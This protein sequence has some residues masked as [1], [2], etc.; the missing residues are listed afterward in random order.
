MRLIVTLLC[1]IL[2]AGPFVA[3][4]AA[5]SPAP[6]NACALPEQHQLDFWLGEWELSWPGDQ[7]GAVDHGT[8]SIRRT[9]DGCVVE[10]N[11]SAERSGSLRGRSLS[12]FDSSAA[13]WKQTWVDNEGSYLDFNGEFKNG[14]MIFARELTRNGQR[15]QQRMVFKNIAADELD[16]S[17]EASTDGG[18]TWQ[19]KWPIHYKRKANT[20]VGSKGNLK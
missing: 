5:K 15:V 14:Q 18:K 7:P 2:S 17:W 13:Q 3:K 11:F 1:L 8:N 20:G 10:E 6:P 19:V 4:A 12:L 16:W 9:L